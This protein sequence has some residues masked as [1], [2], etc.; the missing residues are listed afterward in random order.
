MNNKVDFLIV[1]AGL[2]GATIARQLTDSGYK[3]LI[4]DRRKHIA[5]NVYTERSVHG[6]DIHKYGAHIMHTSNDRVIEFI[7][8]YSKWD[9]YNH[10]VIAKDEFGDIYHLPFNMNTFYDVFKVSDINDAQRII[11]YE[12]KKYGV[13][14]PTNLEE[15]AINMVG[16]TIYEKLIKDYTEKQWNK[17]CVELAPDIIKRLPLRY[18][19]NNNYFNDKFQGIP[20]DGYTKFVHNIIDNIECK[21][22]VDFAYNDW[23]DKVNYDIIYCGAV[24]E[25]CDYCFGELEWRSLFFVDKSYVYNGHN[26]QGTSVINNVSKGGPTRTIEHMWFMPDVVKPNIESII[27]YEYPDNWSKGKER[28]YPINNA[29][30]NELYRKYLKYI[31]TNMPKIVVGGRLGKYRYFDMDDVILE[32]LN[33]GKI[34]YC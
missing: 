13:D 20:V 10:N 34:K 28:Y 4:I 21:L 30:N 26:G 5:G 23:K 9:T 3:C 18:S 19:W 1:G 33:D 17:K 7:N 22:G 32:A 31:M 25:L 16:K 2:Y 11:K 27:T 8:R 14:N 6:Y 24:D 12:I 29:K 15:Q